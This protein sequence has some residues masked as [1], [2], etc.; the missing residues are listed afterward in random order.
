MSLIHKLLQLKAI[1]T[2]VYWYVTKAFSVWNQKK[3]KKEENV[4]D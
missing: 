1:V 4:L 3:K 2:P